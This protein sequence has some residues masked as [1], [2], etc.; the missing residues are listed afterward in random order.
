MT[1]FEP[2]SLSWLLTR[3]LTL[4]LGLLL[5]LILEFVAQPAALVQV[6]LAIVL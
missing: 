5:L 1:S 4:R 2:Q 6:P 3:P